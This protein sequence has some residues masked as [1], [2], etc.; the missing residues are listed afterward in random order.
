MVV[1]LFLVYSFIRRLVTPFE[2]WDAYKEGIIDEKGNILISRKDFT[3]RAQR[4][5]FGVFDQLILNIKKLLARLPGG[6]TR[7]ASYA[8]AL[9]LIRE[10]ETYAN[11]NVLMEDLALNE[12]YFTEATDRFLAEYGDVIV[13]S[14]QK[15][16]T[17]AGS[18]A[19][20]GLGVGPQGEP[21]VS[22]AASKRYKKKNL[23]DLI[24]QLEEAEMKKFSEFASDLKESKFKVGNLK[25]SSGQT[26]RL[27]RDDIEAL[28]SLMKGIDKRNQDKMLKDLMKN[29][30]EFDE[31]LKFAKEAM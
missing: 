18:G 14:E 24:K 6:T 1:D 5:A 3:T 12:A 23:K 21:G 25:L 27:T 20:A 15:E 22:K 16:M 30:K 26:V 19:I 2:R 9:W 7:L 13:E 17:T 8:A 11:S 28:E 10:N 29:K 4:S 31:I